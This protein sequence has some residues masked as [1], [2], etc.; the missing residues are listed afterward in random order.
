VIHELAFLWPWG[1]TNSN[2]W[3]TLLGGWPQT[4]E[5]IGAIAAGYALVRKHNCHVKGC[6]RIGRH[7]VDGTNYIVCQHH[8]PSD[9]AP[10]HDKILAANKHHQSHLAE[11]EK[12]FHHHPDD[13][14]P[15]PSP[16]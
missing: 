3:T 10:S 6:P 1:D 11:L 15:K 12:R 16:S 14:A 8:H 5:G 7:P 9:Q 13:D 4:L 2:R